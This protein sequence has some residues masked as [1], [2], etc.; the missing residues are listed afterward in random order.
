MTVKA[1]RVLLQEKEPFTRIAAPCPYF[2]TC[3][4]CSLQDLAYPDQLTLKKQR[5][6]RILGA[7]DPTLSIE[8]VGLEDP[9]RYRNKAELTF[10]EASPDLLG[11]SAGTPGSQTGGAGGH[12]TLGY[13]AARSFWRIVDLEDCLLLPE[14]M[15]RLARAVRAFAQRSAQPA[16]NPRRHT[17]FFRYLVIRASYA[18]GQLLVCLITTHGDRRLIEELADTLIAQHSDV[19]SVYWG[20]NA[21]VAD[22]AIP[23]ELF[24][25]RGRPYLEDRVGPFAI[26]LH[27]FTFLQPTPVQAQRLY[28]RLSDMASHAPSGMAWDLYCGIGLV[29]FYL[30]STYRTVYGI[31]SDARNLEMARLNAQEN[32]IRNTEFHL[33]RAEDVLANKRFWLTEAKPEL[34]VVDPPRSGLHPRVIAAVLAARP[35]QLIYVSCNAQALVRDLAPLLSG[36]PRYHLR[37]TAAFDLFPH[38]NHLEVLAL[39]ERS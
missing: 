24:L 19:V 21:K 12:L 37:Q 36:F 18:T 7:L 23:D 9:W 28:E 15:S 39:L 11:H 25:V 5:L 22:V 3:G 4:G 1:D 32:A 20:V 10:S 30:A 6:L 2:G 13:H 27:P 33:G 38:T 34:V 16:Y 31:D 8:V 17:G 26:K 29:A 14:P 35:K